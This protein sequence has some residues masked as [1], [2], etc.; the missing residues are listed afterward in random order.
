[1]TLVIKLTLNV[2]PSRTNHCWLGHSHSDGRVKTDILIWMLQSGLFPKH[3]A[4]VCKGDSVESVQ[5]LYCLDQKELDNVISSLL[6]T[7]KQ[8]EVLE[9]I[10]IV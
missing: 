7:Q 9:Q 8:C 5:L 6:G 4:V 3:L 1:M 10:F 2:T